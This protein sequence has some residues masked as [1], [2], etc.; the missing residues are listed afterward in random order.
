M[1][2]AKTRLTLVRNGKEEKLVLRENYVTFADPG[3]T[4]SEV[5]APVVFVGDG[6]TALELGYDD[7]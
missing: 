4:V 5:E 6:V 3:R 7:Y 2:E 1:D